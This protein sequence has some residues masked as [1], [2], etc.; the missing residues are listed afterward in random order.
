ME[1]ALSQGQWL[2]LAGG[3]AAAFVVLTAPIVVGQNW[4]GEWELVQMTMQN[5]SSFW[6]AIMQTVTFLGSSTVGL[7]LSAGYTAVLLVH[8][9]RL[10]RRVC[11][12]LAAMVGSAPINFG[13]RAAV[14]RYRPEVSFIPNQMPE[15]VHPFQRWSYPSGHAMTATICYGVAAYLVIQVY[16]RAGWKVLFLYALW[17]AAVG[18]SRV[19]LGVHWPSD[20]LSG[21]LVGGFW[22]G[23]CIVVFCRKG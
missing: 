4:P 11:L 6:T 20:V 3:C 13:L 8:D 19:Y 1:G 18:F 21:Y 15:L 10:T 12:P 22:L 16:P 2:W 7:G 5:R 14:G 17:L 9:R 23:M